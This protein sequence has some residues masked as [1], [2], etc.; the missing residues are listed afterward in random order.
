MKKYFVT[1]F[2]DYKLVEIFF[3]G[4]IS[5]MPFSILTS[6]L[7]AFLKDSQ[8]PLELI[9]TFAVARMSYALKFLWAPVL[10]SLKMPY[11]YKYGRRK[12]WL[13]L[14]TTLNTLILLT[15]STVSVSTGLSVLYILLICVGFFSATFDLN[16]D[17]FRIENIEDDKQGIAVANAVLG[18]R[19]GMI[20]T[21]AGALYCA[22]ITNS[23][24]QTFVIL[25]ILFFIALCFICRVKESFKINNAENTKLTNAIKKLTISSFVDFFSKEYSWLILI[26]VILFK[27]SDA[28]LGSV[29]MPFYLELGFNKAQ[30]ALVVKG[31][32]VIATL[33]GVYVGGFIIRKFGAINALISTGFAQSI[34]NASFIWLHYQDVRIS[35]LFATIS[36]ENFSGGMGTTALVTYI[37]AL[38]N[39]K[40]SATQYGLLSAAAVFLNDTLTMTSGNLVKM[41]GWD[42]YFFMTVILGFPSIMIFY[43][44]NKK[45]L[46]NH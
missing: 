37:S 26:A 43:Y 38:C 9:T 8:V 28:M 10:D 15:I 22:H 40:Y 42:S 1:N 5:G 33:C 4:I 12:S 3:L 16:V 41:L 29:S 2:S 13:M 20:L 23:W 21:G 34:T 45:L 31:F 30:I 46:A 19:L 17:A 32:G 27:M 11:L 35:A 44:L 39:K 25:G 24:S 6:T 7:S 18:Y 36:L 14:C